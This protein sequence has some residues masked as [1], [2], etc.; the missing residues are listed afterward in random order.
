[1]WRWCR[2]MATMVMRFH[3]PSMPSAIAAETS[4]C[5]FVTQRYRVNILVGATAKAEAMHGASGAAGLL[6]CWI[7]A[8]R[9]MDVMHGSER[10]VMRTCAGN[11]HC[12]AINRRRRP[13]SVR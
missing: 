3:G 5:V 4:S 11:Q 7:Q 13:S 6:R 1:M 9:S 2:L 10:N 12:D 8:L